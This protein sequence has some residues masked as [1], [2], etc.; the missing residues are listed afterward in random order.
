[1]GHLR[2]GAT[3]ILGVALCS[4]LWVGCGSGASVEEHETGPD[5]AVQGEYRSASPAVGAQVIAR[6]G[7]TFELSLLRGGLPGDGWDGSDRERFSGR[8][9]GDV[10][11]FEEIQL[12]IEG[13]VL[14]GS[15]PELG[16]LMLE[17]VERSSP[18]L[19]ASPPEGAKV[20]FG[21]PG[22]NAFDG[23]VDE[24]GF[25][26]SGATSRET[27]GSFD[28]H[29]EFRTP[30]MPTSSGQ[31]RGNSGVYLQERY[32]VQVLDSFGEDG[33]DNECGGI[34]EFRAPLLN[35]ALPPL[36]WQ[37]YDMEFRAAQFDEEGNRSSQARLTVR[38]NGVLIHK[39]IR[40]DG[41]TG[42]G[43]PEGPTPG[44]L[45][46]QDHWN[47][48]FYRNVWLVPQEALEADSGGR[49]GSPPGSR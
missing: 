17:R 39:D 13:G 14:R 34:Y 16:A 27:F 25:L 43:D 4:A 5:F 6:G 35:M 23:I 3:L 37:T 22:Q 7:G 47:P 20:L 21:G 45:L 11:P 1:L 32:E 9:K 30:F 48:V 24:R 12:R 2:S 40:L 31:S 29:V 10:I 26:A 15:H 36:A 46:L 18:T 19:G 38:H 42:L 8:W 41:P 44:A 33:A 49:P 28:L